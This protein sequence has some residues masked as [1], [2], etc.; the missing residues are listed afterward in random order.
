M[1][2]PKKENGKTQIGKW[3]IAKRMLYS[4][5]AL[6]INYIFIFKQYHNVEVEEQCCA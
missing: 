6:M 5:N 3:P 2:F 4:I 1:G